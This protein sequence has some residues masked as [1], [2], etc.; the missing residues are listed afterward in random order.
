MWNIHS[1]DKHSID[2][3][4]FQSPRPFITVQINKDGTLPSLDVP[5]NSR[6]RLMCN[7]NLPMAKLKRACDYAQVKWSTYSVSFVNNSTASNGVESAKNGKALNMRNP[8]NQEK[9]LR[10]FMDSREIDDSVRDRVV[11]LSRDYLKKVDS[12][13]PIA[14]NVVWDIKKMMELPI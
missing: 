4:L 5:K 7:H 3:R 1:K 6:L 13:S 14:R 2:K 8:D 9:F 10:E 11:E 12:S